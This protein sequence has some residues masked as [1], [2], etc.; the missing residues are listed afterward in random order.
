MTQVFEVYLSTSRPMT[1]YFS[2]WEDNTFIRFEDG[3]VTD[4]NI[5]AFRIRNQTETIE[6]GMCCTTIKY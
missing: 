1:R 2:K 5:V 4:G 3:N 6:R